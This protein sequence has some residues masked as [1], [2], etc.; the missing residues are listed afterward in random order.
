MSLPAVSLQLQTLVKL[1]S[2]KCPALLG[3]NLF[4]FFFNYS[5]LKW[6]MKCSSQTWSVRLSFF[7]LSRPYK[8][9]FLL[10]GKYESTKLPGEISLWADGP[11]PGACRLTFSPGS[12]LKIT[13]SRA[14]TEMWDSVSVYSGGFTPC[15]NPTL[16]PKQQFSPQS[17]KT[18]E[19]KS[20]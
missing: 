14:H 8:V 4:S 3:S 2:S 11:S 5:I 1:N 20:K 12:E 18:Q 7:C 16:L 17:E 9:C 13:G 10:Q 19:P 6:G 15:N